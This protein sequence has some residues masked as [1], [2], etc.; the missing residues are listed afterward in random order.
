MINDNALPPLLTAIVPLTRMAGRLENL[1]SWLNLARDHSIQIV[2]AHD[3][4]DEVTGIELRELLN[5]ENNR[6]IELIEGNFGAPGLARNAGIEVARGKWVTFWDSDDVPQVNRF[7][8]MLKSTSGVDI[9]CFVGGY[10]TVNDFDGEVEERILPSNH[11]ESIALNPGI[12]RFAFKR[13]SLGSLRFSNLLMAEDQLFLAHYNISKRN[14]SIY[15]HSIYN[16][17]VGGHFHQTRQKKA[18]ENLL[19]S[20]E[21][22]FKVLQNTSNSNFRFVTILLCRQIVTGIK[23]GSF[24]IR[25]KFFKVIL[26]GLRKSPKSIYPEMFNAGYLTYRMKRSTK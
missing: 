21:E 11:L 3:V 17:Y 16:Y 14:L 4:Q 18:L 22:S 12:W 23:H 2:I 13:E 10:S 15:N 8:S 6:R 20:V 1:G 5:G 19:S 7:V 26:V 9:D 25:L 24:F